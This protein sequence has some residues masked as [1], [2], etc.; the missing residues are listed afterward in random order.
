M[1]ELETLLREAVR[2]L[3]AAG[4]ESALL[5]AR[6]LVQ[7]ATGLSHEELILHPHHDVP[8]DV[9]DRLAQ[10]IA[11]RAGREPVS[12]I[13]GQREFYGHTFAITEHVLDPRPDSELLVETALE[14]AKRLGKTRLRLLDLGTGSG[15]LLISLLDALP[16]AEGVGVDVSAKALACARANAERLGVAA[17][18]A[19][20]CGSWLAPVE[21]VFDIV[22]SNPPYIRSGEIAHLQ[23]EVQGHDPVLALDGG[24][25]GVRPYR[26]IMGG[27]GRVLA[28]GGAVYCEIGSDQAGDVMRIMTASGVAAP[29]VFQDLAGHDRVIGGF[30]TGNSS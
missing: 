14:A 24:E 16:Q 5:D 21:G 30:F 22:I 18:A 6:L 1:A 15:C 2:Q 13:L 27:L 29:A 9:Q 26:E 3:Q 7:A 12:R 28:P 10:M 20:V 4:I 25:S 23:P 11:R 19:F 8:E 17:R